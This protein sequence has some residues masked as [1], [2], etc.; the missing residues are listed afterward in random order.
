M[1]LRTPD[2]CKQSLFNVN[3]SKSA[4]LE[5]YNA[6]RQ[7]LLEITYIKIRNGTFC[8]ILPI[9]LSTLREL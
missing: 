1:L 5:I 6:C 7:K 2:H 3:L 9:L 4:N 8:P